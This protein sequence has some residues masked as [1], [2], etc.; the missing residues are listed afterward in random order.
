MCAFTVEPPSSV[1]SI[2]AERIDWFEIWQKET[3]G[4]WSIFLQLLI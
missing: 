1:F 2:A 4:R 3:F